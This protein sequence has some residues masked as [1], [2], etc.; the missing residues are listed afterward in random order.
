MLIPKGTGPMAR[1]IRLRNKRST[2]IK[3]NIPSRMISTNIGYNILLQGLTA[4]ANITGIR[5]RT[6]INGRACNNGSA[7]VIISFCA[8]PHASSFMFLQG[9]MLWAAAV[10]TL[11]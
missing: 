9:L 1:T 2:N 11:L 7:E 8:R 3:N 6:T 5:F 4:A 10:I